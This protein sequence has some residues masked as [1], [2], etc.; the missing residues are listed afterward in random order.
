MRWSP[1]C[2]WGFLLFKRWYW[3]IEEPA[4]QNVQPSLS[5][6]AWLRQLTLTQMWDHQWHDGASFVGPAW[7]VSA[8]FFAYAL[9]PIAALVFF[10]LGRWRGRGWRWLFGVFAVVLLAPES[11]RCLLTG[12]PYFPFSWLARVLGGFTSGVL[13]YLVVR[14]IPRTPRVRRV[15]S[16]LSWALLGLGLAGLVLGAWLGPGP[17]GV[18]AERGGVVLLL[19]PPLVGA[20]SLASGLL[21]RGLSTPAVVMAD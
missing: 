14:D 1:R 18:S 21:V 19:F 16:L 10:R 13:V 4:Y 20:L 15:A 5:V 7:S 8:E 2:S 9:F 3:G 11:V 17:D 12:S 6:G